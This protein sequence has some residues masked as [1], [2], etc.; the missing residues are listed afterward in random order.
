MDSSCVPAGF[1]YLAAVGIGFAAIVLS[2]WVVMLMREAY[3]DDGGFRASLMTSAPLWMAGLTGAVALYHAGTWLVGWAQACLPAGGWRPAG[4]VIVGIGF[5]I[6]VTAAVRLVVGR[7]RVGKAVE[8]ME[9]GDETSLAPSS[10]GQGDPVRR[11]P[12]LPPERRR[13]IVEYALTHGA[14]VIVILIGVGLA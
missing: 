1:S 4:A 7:L 5:T 6:A 10:T 13:V 3:R 9:N 2:S 8:P 11:R 14:A 12:K